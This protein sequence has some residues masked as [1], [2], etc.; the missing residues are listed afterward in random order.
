MTDYTT[1][2]SSL[3]DNV[4]TAGSKMEESIVA[5]V[6]CRNTHIDTQRYVLSIQLHSVDYLQHGVVM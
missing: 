4:P 3:A 2:S 5:N 1:P 6:R